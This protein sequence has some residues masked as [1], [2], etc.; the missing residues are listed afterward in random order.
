VAAAWR[1]AFGAV[2]QPR[3]DE[4]AASVV[5]PSYLGAHRLPDL[6]DALAEQDCRE[7]WEVVL[8]LDGPP[9]GSAEVA[10]RYTG[11]LDLTVLRS[12]EP[13]GT[14]HALNAGYAAA[15]GRVLIRCDDDL[16]PAPDM[17]RRHVEHH[18]AGPDLGVI[19]LTRD[20]FP[21]TRYAAAY[22]EA[23]NRRSL[24]AAYARPPA[25]RWL[26]WAAHNSLTR[27]TWDRAGGF[28]TRF[29]YG[30]DYE[31][32]LRLRE[33]GVR[34][35]IDPAL[36]LGH[37]GPSVVAATRVPRAY[38]SGASR[39]LVETVHGGLPLTVARPTGVRARAW[40]AAVSAVTALVR[41]RDGFARLGRLADRVLEVVPPAVGGPLV[42]LL[43]EAAGRSG[44][45]HGN[46]DLRVYTAQKR[47]ELHREAARA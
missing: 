25:E 27:Q 10:A 14:V 44:R 5:V 19:G 3:S 40:A 1:V 12:P 32:G 34:F 7:P 16:T 31:L 20:V 41:T 39:R 23:A 21:A 45:R 30:Q 17:V 35:V 8:V 11:A 9:D 37:R 38:V 6:L 13:H 33:A 2:S 36:E 15:R 46:P 22:G 4:V 26:H 43:V 42:A 29:V 24:D 28:D 18:R 47:A